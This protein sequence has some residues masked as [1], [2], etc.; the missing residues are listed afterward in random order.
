MSPAIEQVG[1]VDISPDPDKPP[2]T[3]SQHALEG[4]RR[5]IVYGQLRP[6]NRIRE[7]EIAQTLGVSLAPIREAL[8][9][10]EEEGQV[11]YLRR[12]GYF[13]TELRVADLEEIYQLCKLLE[14]RAARHTLP[15]L[16]DEA[17]ERIKLAARDW[18]DAARIG[19]VAGQL[20]ANRRFHFA[21][22]ESPDQTQTM[23]IIHLLWDSTETYRAMYYNSPVARDEA[24]EAHQRIIESISDRDSRRLVAELDAHRERALK[25]LTVILSPD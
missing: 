22:L 10:L 18:V 2:G 12:R 23:R 9:V 5:A 15:L 3:T 13:V 1:S 14:D 6:G 4:L 25:L 24:H 21:I 20:A 8:A 11:T 17:I 19:D 7:E 16:D